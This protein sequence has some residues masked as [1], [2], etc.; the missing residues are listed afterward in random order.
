MT[1]VSVCV[2][3]VCFV[4]LCCAAPTRSKLETWSKIIAVVVNLALVVL[5][6]F[7]LIGTFGSFDPFKIIMALYIM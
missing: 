6:V 7:G 2:S 5:G 3:L 4:L 1:D